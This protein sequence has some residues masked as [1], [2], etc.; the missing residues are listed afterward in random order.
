LARTSTPRKH[1]RWGDILAPYLFLLPFILFFFVMFLGPATYAFVL[2]FFRYRG[3]GTARWVGLGNYAALLQYDV[4]W[5]QLKNTLFYWIAHA[6]PMMTVAFLLA[7]LMQSKLIKNQKRFKP[8]I[9]LP[10]IVA[11]VAA[12]LLFRNLFGT[13]YGI[14]NKLLGLKIAWMED[15]V[16]TRWIVVVVMIW[17]STGYWFVIYLAGLTSISPSV[18]EAAIVDGASWW[19]RLTHVILP[20]MRNSFIFAFVVDGISSL[21]AYAVP[22]I[23]GAVGGELAPPGVASILVLLV[24]NIRDGRFGRASATGWLLFIVI[25]VVSG[26][27]AILLG[28]RREGVKGNA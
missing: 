8:I 13:Q 5:K 14:V 19:Q 27:Q 16:L 20:L 2:S 11:N 10:Q 6:L 15:P 23:I 18:L 26:I 1:R 17:R 12:A 24:Q 4:F 3:Y 21:R 7:L 25:A 22:N 9:F 28:K